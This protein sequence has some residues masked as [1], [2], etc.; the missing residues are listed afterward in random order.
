MQR[1]PVETTL[2][3]S[4]AATGL[5]YLF[6]RFGP[7]LISRFLNRQASAGELSPWSEPDEEWSFTPDPRADPNSPD[8][9]SKLRVPE[10]P[11]ERPPASGFPFGLGLGNYLSPRTRDLLSGDPHPDVSNWESAQSTWQKPIDRGDSQLSRTLQ[12]LKDLKF[13]NRLSGAS[14][15]LENDNPF[16]PDQQRAEA[17]SMLDL[18]N[19]E[20]AYGKGQEARNYIDSTY[21][22]RPT[23]N[24]T[25]F[26]DRHF[27]LL[28]LHEAETERA[29]PWAYMNKMPGPLQH[30]LVPQ[31]EKSLGGKSTPYERSKYPLPFPNW[32]NEI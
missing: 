11:P 26:L 8:V 2:G 6:R 12:A 9:L 16:I 7:D 27:N 25:D 32:L 18:Y 28:K 24:L 15:L 10:P 29:K 1:H 21:G 31:L 17:Q 5:L 30:L 19:Q 22:E 20:E 4:A 14:D 23:A 13:A 3:A